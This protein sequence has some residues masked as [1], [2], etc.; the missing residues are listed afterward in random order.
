[1][2]LHSRKTYTAV[3]VW[4][5]TSKSPDRGHNAGKTNRGDRCWGQWIGRH[6]DLPGGGTA[7]HL[8]WRKRWHWRTVEIWG[9]FEE[10]CAS[11]R[12]TCFPYLGNWNFPGS[13]TGIKHWLPLHVAAQS[14]L[15][16][17]PPPVH[18]LP[19]LPCPKDDVQPAML[20]CR[21]GPCEQ[22][23]MP[24]LRCPAPWR[25]SQRCLTTL[26]AVPKAVRSN[27]L[28]VLIFLPFSRGSNNVKNRTPFMRCLSL[29]S[30]I[31]SLSFSAFPSQ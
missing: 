14:L 1:M 27:G 22:N 19:A 13:N 28:P 23:R 5:Y 30:V 10:I 29:V 6:Q 25:S 9:E 15:L 31:A 3:R 7:A 21:G 12:V 16:S 20:L 26:A 2:I 8:F 4:L 24:A 17:V 18:W 11:I